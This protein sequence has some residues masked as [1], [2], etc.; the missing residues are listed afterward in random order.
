MDPSAKDGQSRQ[1]D[2]PAW[3]QPP[4]AE[5]GHD[6]EVQRRE[7]GIPVSTI[8]TPIQSNAGITFR[9]PPVAG[10]NRLIVSLGIQ[11]VLPA[12]KNCLGELVHQVPR[13]FEPL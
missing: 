11:S 5:G 12:C 7:N 13:D 8:G 6:R 4:M 10:L 3:H 1:Q 2:G 9:R